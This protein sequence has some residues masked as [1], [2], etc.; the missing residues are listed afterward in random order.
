MKKILVALCM[1][2]MFVLGACSTSKAR[3]S[4]EYPLRIWA[5]NQ[6]GDYRTF[7]VVD[8]TTG[9]NYIVASGECS[10]CRSV[11]ITP[12]YNADGTLYVSK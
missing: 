6:N 7:C 1:V 4:Q 2:S 10:Y 9:V 3:A 11:A 5:Q 8:D 12:R